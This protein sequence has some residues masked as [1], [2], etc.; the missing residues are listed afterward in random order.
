MLL[1]RVIEHVKTQNWTAVGIDFVIVVVG[2]FI[3]IQVSNWNA[4]RGERAAETR[5][6]ELLFDEVQDNVA[7]SALIIYRAGQLQLD[8][9]AAAAKLR[10][11][12]PVDGDAARGLVNMANFRD[13]TP[14]HAAYDEL[15]S[16][17]DITLIQS[18][19]VR[20]AMAIFNGV[21]IFHDR[22]RQE[23]LDRAPDIMRLA[24]DHMKVDY[25]PAQPL[26][27]T[28]EMDW[29]AA[30]DDRALLN[31]VNRVMGDQVAFNV[32]REFILER[33]Q[34]LCD[35]ISEVLAKPCAP[36]DWVGNEI[37]GEPYE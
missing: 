21:V 18:Q 12:E 30:A 33:V 13:L 29:A 27:Y 26:G 19:E 22:A 1:R 20:S 9:E 7:Y 10:G 25:D 36:P 28:I 4:A 15:K 2:V 34:I 5:A 14:I 24:S 8:R 23:Y 6:L 11:L 31:A 17:G 32:R 3:G 37:R 16:S 35:A